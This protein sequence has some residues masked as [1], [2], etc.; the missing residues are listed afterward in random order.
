MTS[1]AGNHETTKAQH[2]GGDL[3]SCF[4]C[5]KPLA[6]N[7]FCRIQR[8]GRLI[9]LCDPNSLLIYLKTARG[10]TDDRQQELDAYENSLHFFVGGDKPWQ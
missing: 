4:A 5:G 1:L 3:G 9:V 10:P 7:W 2:S 6:E 8:G